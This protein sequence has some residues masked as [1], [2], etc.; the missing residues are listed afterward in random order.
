[1]TVKEAKA[2]VF[3]TAFRSMTKAERREIL[4][5]MM[6]DPKVRHDLTDLGVFIERV[7]EPSRPFRKYLSERG[8]I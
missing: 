2:E 3:Y 1:M 8:K 5:K 4:S 6:E 7:N